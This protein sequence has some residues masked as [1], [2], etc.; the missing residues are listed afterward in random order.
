MFLCLP[1]SKDATT[2]CKTTRLPVCDSVFLVYSGR[3]CSDATAKPE[4]APKPKPIGFCIGPVVIVF[5]VLTL[6]RLTDD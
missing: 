2:F 3:G 5:S 4:Q 1:S 6:F